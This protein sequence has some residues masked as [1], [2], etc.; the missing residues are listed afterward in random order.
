[1][2]WTVRQSIVAAALALGVFAG[3]RRLAAQDD[4]IGIARGATPPAVQ[5]QDLDGQPA[6]FSAYVG[7]KPVLVEFWATWCTNCRALLPRM[8]AAYQRYGSRVEFLVVGVG[9]NQTRDTMRRHL[10]SHQMPFRF[11]FDATGSAVRA[12]EAPAT[13][14]VVVLD[15]QG[16]VVYTGVGPDQDLDAALRRAVGR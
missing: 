14:Y 15:A 3:P 8:Q 6:D 16:R 4:A 1:M 11:F 5:V 12:F 13:S 7:H 2:T 9:V 10:Q